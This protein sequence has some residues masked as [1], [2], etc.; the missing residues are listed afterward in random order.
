MS[1]IESSQMLALFAA[2]DLDDLVEAAF[3]VLQGTVACDF[4]SAFYR[5]SGKGLLKERD[6]RGRESSPEFMRRYVELSPARR[7]AV[8]N[9]GIKLILTRAALPRSEAEL[10]RTPFYREIMQPQGWRHAVALCFWGDPP[11]ESPV[12][13]A[14]VNRREGQSDFSP[15]DIAR[16]ESIHPFIDC[17]VNRVHER[18]AAKS[19]RDGMAMTVRD[20]TRGL[21]VLDWNLRLV[22]ANPIARRMCAAW[23]EDGKGTRP[24]GSSLSARSWRLPPV[25]S[26][27]CRELQREWASL[28]RANPDARVL[29]R[30][31]GISH[32][33]V[34]DLT[35]AIT[36]VWSDTTGLSEPS[37]VV[38]FDRRLPSVPVLQKMTAAERGVAMVLVDGLSNQEIADRLAKSV[39]AVKFLLHRIYRKTGVPN[40]AALVAAMGARHES[41]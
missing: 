10:R 41:Q 32:P 33:R 31:P 5:S 29:R 22:E 1:S 9:P 12:F 11:A 17:A 35:A 13:V 36:M 26:D 28:L 18:D 20:G 19:V 40:R 37:F 8:A 27:A 21:A 30:H 24:R 14:S 2:K 23:S 25:L 6:S 4:A 15:L 39:H 3:R 16:L 7:L 38:E 34:P